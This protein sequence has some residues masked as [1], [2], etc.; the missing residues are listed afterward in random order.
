MPGV[1]EQSWGKEEESGPGTEAGRVG[2][3]GEVT[4]ETRAGLTAEG[5]GGLEGCGFYSEQ[6][7]ES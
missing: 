1:F 6:N 4:Q 7:C 5:L 2:A 3:R